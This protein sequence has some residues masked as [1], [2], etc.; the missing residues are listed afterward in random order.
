LFILNKCEQVSHET[1]CWL[2]LT[3][4]HANSTSPFIHYTSPRLRRE[5]KQE[6]AGLATEFGKLFGSLTTSRRQDAKELHLKLIASQ[7]EQAATMRDLCQAKDLQQNAEAEADNIRQN[8]V[9]VQN[10]NA[11]QA[12]MLSALKTRLGIT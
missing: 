10:E 2:F 3:A 1:G 6:V 7:E 11:E 5:S 12:A 4:Q 8:L 9:R